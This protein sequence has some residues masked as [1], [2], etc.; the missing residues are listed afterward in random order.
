MLTK[1]MLLDRKNTLSSFATIISSAHGPGLAVDIF[2]LSA[3]ATIGLAFLLSIIAEHGALTSSTLMTG[4][5]F[6]S[7]VLNGLS[8]GSAASVPLSG[9]IGICYVASGVIL[10]L[11]NKHH[12]KQTTVFYHAEGQAGVGMYNKRPRRI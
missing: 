12:R 6:V 9:W 4:R 1:V 3:S 2:L 11:R 7:I 5:Q 10:E 8:F